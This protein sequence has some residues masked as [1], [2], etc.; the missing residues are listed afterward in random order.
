MMRPAS[1]L[2]LLALMA[3]AAL[4]TPVYAE[5][6]VSANDGKLTL[7]DGKI[8]V[9]KDGKD[10]I[11]F[12]DLDST[13]PKLIVEIEAP[14]SV[15]GP[16]MSVAVSPKEDFALVT[17][18][19]KI[20]PADPTKQ[21]PDNRISVIDLIQ[22]G[23]GSIVGSLKKA[24]GL[25]KAE[26]PK[27]PKIL[28]TVEAGAGA[29]GVSINSSGTVALVANRAEG[30]V[31][32]FT[33]A[34]KV[35]TPAGKI[36]LGNKDSGPSHVVFA[37]DG[38]TAL[39]TRDRDHKISVLSVD[40]NKVEYTKRDMNAGLNPYGI[41]ATAKGN[42]AVVANIGVGQGDDDTISMIDMAAKVSRVVNT[43]TVGQTPEG[44]KISPDGKYVAVGVMNGSNKP[45]D[46][47][48]FAENGKLLIYAR[49]GRE[50]TK[51][52]EAPVGK[53]CQGI[54]W[55]KKSSLVL[56]QCMV[57]Q[58]IHVFKFTGVT[59]KGL[60]KSSTIKTTGGPAG[61]RTAEK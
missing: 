36:D 24:A 55:N 15:V 29:S 17:S 30:T 12:I 6:A 48:F 37:G 7:V 50:L 60:T 59:A 18:A 41:D 5:I 14:T 22:D 35:L 53:W 3:S 16:P 31:S 42:Y 11:S 4:A 52:A 47:P 2:S 19:M 40:G 61:I 25:T 8:V 34:G 20:D 54:A 44:I 49:N 57:E 46:S 23:G 56:V 39:V 32:V 27:P 9:N 33:I 21:V 26:A 1:K 51:V 10:T 38:K 45:K 13:P 43:I 58:E 28:A